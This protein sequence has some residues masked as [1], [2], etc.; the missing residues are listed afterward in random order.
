MFHRNALPGRP[1]GRTGSL[2]IPPFHNG[3]V[4]VADWNV[5]RVPG[6]SSLL[7]RC[8]PL[9]G[10]P[11]EPTACENHTASKGLKTDHSPF[12]IRHPSG[13]ARIS[14]D[15]SCRTTQDYGLPASRFNKP[16]RD[17]GRK[18]TSG[19]RIVRL[20][21]TTS[22]LLAACASKGLSALP[23]CRWRLDFVL[24]IDRTNSMNGTWTAPVRPIE[25]PTLL[26][27]VLRCGGTILVVRV[28]AAPATRLSILDIPAPPILSLRKVRDADTIA[29]VFRAEEV[30]KEAADST[31]AWQRRLLARDSAIAAPLA[32]LSA[33]IA[34]ILAIPM[35]RKGSP[36]CGAL[37]EI[38]EFLDRPH[39]PGFD[40]AAAVLFLSDLI[41]TD[42][43]TSC[44]APLHAAGVFT[45]TGLRPGA[46]QLR[47]TPTRVFSV[48]ELV[49]FIDGIT[50]GGPGVH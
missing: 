37:H 3:S 34:S 50:K 30:R 5:Q 15:K 42:G 2:L 39:S 22:I 11:A 33:S 44:A 16:T 18:P 14:R 26:G 7:A 28:D 20:L 6:R 12:A 29:A 27:P 38:S 23:P 32:A 25:I 21:A 49:E 17:I 41:P 8:R 47:P 35:D 43:K 45:M 36:V 13:S 40:R 48:N 9:D 24:V 46:V 19:R 31:A 1:Y 10:C 4:A